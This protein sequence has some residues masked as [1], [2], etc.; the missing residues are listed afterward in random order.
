MNPLPSSIDFDLEARLKES[1]FDQDFAI[2]VLTKTLAKMSLLQSKRRVRALFTF[3]GHANCGKHYL[4]EL[5]VRFDP[6]L[7]AIKTFYMDQY[8][9][10]TD[11]LSPM[12]IETQIIDFVK[13]NPAAI[14]LFKD[15]EKADLQV[16]LS[17]YTL[18]SGHEKSA[19]DFSQVVVIMTTTCLAALLQR[20]DLQDLFKNDPLQAHT[21]L[22]ER[23]GREQVLIN[24]EKEDAF[25]KKLLSLLNEHTLVPFSRL[26]LM[27]LIKIGAQALHEMSQYVITQGHIEV[28]YFDIDRFV[29]LL[30]LSLAPYLNAKHIR[31]KLP[32]IVFTHLYE[33]LKGQKAVEKICFSVS[34]KAKLFA[35]EVL[36]D[37]KTL[38]K[39][40]SK[41]HKRIT[42]KWSVLVKNSVI[43]CTIKDAFYE[44]EK[45]SI[46]S[47]DAL[48]VSDVRF[49][50]IAGQQRVKDEL[51]EVL[52]L[53]KEPQRLQHFGMGIPKG[54]VLYGPSG[55]GKRLL[56]RA[57]ASEADMPYI[58]IEDADLFN[59]AKIKQAYAHAYSAAPA[60]VI[61]ENIDIRGLVS[62][63][64]STMNTTSL[65]EELDVLPQSY[66]SPVFTIATLES[67]ENIPEEL[68]KT[69]RIDIH[70]EVPKLDMDARRFFIQEILKKPHAAN[71]DIERVVRYISG[72]NGNELN[73]IGQEASL[74][75]A[76]KGLKELTEEILLEQINIIKYGVKLE[77]K[78][79][80][81]I[82]T[83]MAKTA[84]HEAGH[85]VL[86]YVLLP[87]VNIEQVTVSPRSQSLGFVSYH[88]DDYIDATS[89]E[90]IFNNICVLLAGRIAK[91]E[92][93]GE[94][95][96]ETG[97]I[98]DLEIANLQAY[99]AIALFGMD[100][101]L[102]YINISAIEAEYDKHLFSKQIESRIL[103]WISKATQTTEKEVKRLWLAIEAVAQALID[104]EM[105]DGDELQKIIQA[106]QP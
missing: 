81:D 52:T 3:I 21:F 55:M 87:Q 93:F 49:K 36:N 91:M 42:L 15:I 5:L 75:A 20:Q 2:E 70:I 79:I 40:V 65:I 101:E 4:P 94:S 97:A 86:S 39:K 28:E 32:D 104:K 102:G 100:E 72:M 31:K 48:R 95:G 25:D 77:N 7:K 51:N 85:A 19:I 62:G 105:I 8:S 35:K 13:E 60:I 14:L 80:R 66:E 29:T 16:Q 11:T 44:E 64:V 12:S 84:Y 46:A 56:A 67:K 98:N 59:D 43:T 54:M 30:T 1:L 34:R 69:G 76:R 74:F 68:M 71:I 103:A 78:H 89:K 99:A 37:E 33:V 63:M 106:H 17:L 83:S 96:L 88:H 23:L 47:S 90:E 18:F 27:A 6:Q 41:Q 45:L 24:G 57:F 61:L 92:K 38:I 73:R 82:E 58:V 10:S 53:L 9:L 50:D 26:R 22:M